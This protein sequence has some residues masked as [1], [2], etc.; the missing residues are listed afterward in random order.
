MVEKSLAVGRWMTSPRARPLF[1][2]VFAA[3]IAKALATGTSLHAQTLTNPNPPTRASATTAPPEN[4]EPKSCPT[5][6]PGFVQVPGTNTCV[7][8]GGS[9]Q[10]QG[11]SNTR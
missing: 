2:M 9:V 11:A 10:V 6:G 3:V 4:K 1:F 8:I 7:K 5:Y